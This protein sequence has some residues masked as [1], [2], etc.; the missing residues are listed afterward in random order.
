MWHQQGPDSAAGLFHFCAHA[1]KAGSRWHLLG[2]DLTLSFLHLTPPSCWPGHLHVQTS[3][4]GMSGETLASVRT[5]TPASTATPAPSSSS[6][7]RWAPQQGWGVALGSKERQAGSVEMLAEPILMPSWKRD[8]WPPALPR[9]C[10]EEP[11]RLN[12]AS[13]ILSPHSASSPLLPVVCPP[14]LRTGQV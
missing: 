6:T 5:E 3:S 7:P 11:R 4:T 13:S 10:L 8:L 2:S 12:L 1:S 14:G 9:Q